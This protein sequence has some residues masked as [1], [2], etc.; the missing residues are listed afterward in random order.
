[1]LRAPRE[2][3]DD[4]ELAPVIGDASVEARPFPTRAEMAAYL[5]E[6]LATTPPTIVER[7]DGLWAWLTLFYLDI[8]IPVE[9]GGARKVAKDLSRYLTDYNKRRA[10]RHLLR[11]RYKLH[12]LHRDNPERARLLLH[13][14]AHIWSDL[15]EQIY[16][17]MELVRLPGALECADV[18]YFDVEKGG[19][20]RG[21]T[22]RKKG[23]TVRRLGLFIQQLDL[24][25]DVYAMRGPEI[26]AMLPDEYK[27][28]LPKAA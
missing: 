27:R 20:K 4:D 15:E 25:Y 11:A 18:L 24:T 5:A 9:E 22:N 7:D 8:V 26:V 23:G 28:W 16:G 12:N 6:A 2:L 1:M 10:Y 21:V 17:V 14:P 3:L 13:G 19:A